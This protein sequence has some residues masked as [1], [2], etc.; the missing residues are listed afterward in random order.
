MCGDM[1]PRIFLSLKCGLRVRFSICY[2]NPGA[3][4][5]LNISLKYLSEV[6]VCI[7]QFFNTFVRQIAKR[8]GKVIIVEYFQHDYIRQFSKS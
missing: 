6:K 2:L 7:S 1:K 4:V 3:K 8:I 5:F